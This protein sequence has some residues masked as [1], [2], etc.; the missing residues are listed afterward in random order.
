MTYEHYPFDPCNVTWNDLYKEPQIV[1][2]VFKVWQKD[3]LPASTAQEITE[4]NLA[5]D[6][7]VRYMQTY[8]ALW[9]SDFVGSFLT[10]GGKATYFYQYEPLPMYHGCGGW[11]TFGMFNVDNN[12]NIKQDAAEYFSSQILTQE[13]AEPV[14]ALHTVYPARSDIK[15]DRGNVLVTAYALNRPDGQWAVLLVNKDQ[16]NSH[17][18][19]VSFDDAGSGAHYFQD[20]VTEITFGADEYFW[21]ANGANGYAMP[22][23]PAATSTEGGGKG[24]QYVLPKA[25]V[26]VLRGRIDSDD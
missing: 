17:P 11:G 13:W 14:D 10:V 15:D 5:F 24:T 8:A 2:H 4:Y 6:Q 25:S 3:G 1:A 19:Y 22:D 9:H 26:T 20:A 18:V 7:S 12:Y 23:G 21:H 16:H